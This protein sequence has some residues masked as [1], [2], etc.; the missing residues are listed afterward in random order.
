MPPTWLLM[1]SNFC[2]IWLYQPQLPWTIRCGY[3]PETRQ[4]THSGCYLSVLIVSNTPDSTW[5]QSDF[6]IC[7]IPNL[8]TWSTT[9]DAHMW[10]TWSNHFL[11]HISHLSLC[12]QV[13]SS[14][15]QWAPKGFSYFSPSEYHA[16]NL[17]NTCSILTIKYM[18][19]WS[20]SQLFNHI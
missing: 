5:P 4:T 18:T 3:Y 17:G 15:I 1:T 20:A 19:G 13:P 14:T 9:D 10:S 11:W 2:N 12:L 16:C 7:D 8:L 6:L